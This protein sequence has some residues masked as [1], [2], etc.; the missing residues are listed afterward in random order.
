MPFVNGYPGVGF[1][2]SISERREETFAHARTRSEGM[3]RVSDD[4][5]QVVG[6]VCFGEV[7][8]Y[9]WSG[10]V[11]LVSVET[12]G[13]GSWIELPNGECC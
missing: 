12:T 8:F 5:C 10:M 9:C 3:P 2:P 4:F 7:A 11:P 13:F 6:K 1:E